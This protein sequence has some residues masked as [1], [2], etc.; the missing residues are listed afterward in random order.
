[1]GGDIL[2]SAADKGFPM[3]G[4]SLLNR[5]G[6]FKQ[7]VDSRG[8]QTASYNKFRPT[9]ELKKLSA[10]ISLPLKDRL[11]QVGVWRMNIVGPNN[12][13]VPVY[14]LDTNLKENDV[15]AR[16]L[17]DELYGG[18]AINRLQQEIILGRGGLKM[19]HRLGY[20]NIKTTHINEAHGALAGV[21][22]YLR[23]K[24]QKFS[25][26][27]SAVKSQLAFTTHT[28]LYQ[29]ENIFTPETLLAYQPDFPIDII[30]KLV[31]NGKI[32]FMD[33]AAFLAGRINAVSALHRRA[34][35]KIFLPYKL[36]SI[37]N[38]VNS[39]FW[40]SPEMKKLYNFYLPEWRCRTSLLK[41]A[42]RIPLSDIW[43]AHQSAKRRLFSFIKKKTG[44]QLDLAVFTIGFA[45]RF[46]TYKR[47]L[48]LFSDL[49]KLKSLSNF[50]RGLQIIYAGKAHPRDKVGQKLIQEIHSLKKKLSLD[51]KIVFLADYD[52]SQAQLMT[53]GVDLW[54]N[55]PLP[56][57]EASGTSGMKAAHNGV[58]QLSTAD[59]WWPEACVIGK[60]GWL[61]KEKG[62]LN[63]YDVLENKIMRIYYDQ[64]EKWQRI[65][66]S[67]IAI[68]A[69]RFNTG[70]ALEE[71]IRRMY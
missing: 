57:Q 10:R 62:G 70:R 43:E 26:K 13:I 6:Y 21:E 7:T 3:V 19:L 30:N 20:R 29:N 32:R 46:V 49:E 42:A 64:P 33:L 5:Y 4:I 44:T 18:D 56:P 48:L 25:E 23:T 53:A 60:T 16:R 38:G 14:F 17:T 61:I 55:T 1:L 15:E 27:I 54:L 45:R 40:T 9:K 67:T 63:L 31:E 52:L 68:N 47:P 28:I 24:S 59:G 12:F 58:P 8:R 37:T 69:P 71:Y 36:I 34:A 66:R 50:G 11:V 65:M 22:L 51:I 35:R 39:Y 41:K 2:K